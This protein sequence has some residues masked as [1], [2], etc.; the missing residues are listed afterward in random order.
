MFVHSYVKPGTFSR[1]IHDSCNVLAYRF[2]QSG[3]RG[4]RVEHVREKG[5][6]GLG[7]IPPRS[8]TGSDGENVVQY[9]KIFRHL[10]LIMAHKDA[11]YQFLS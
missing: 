6:A 2:P 5:P 11:A 7:V 4:C 8:E 10:S 9:P 3:F 1:L